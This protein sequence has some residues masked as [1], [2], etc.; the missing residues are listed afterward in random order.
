MRSESARQAKRKIKTL[1]IK[2]DEKIL[3]CLDRDVARS[4]EQ[5]EEHKESYSTIVRRL[6]RRH[7]K[8]KIVSDMACE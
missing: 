6:L 5:R 4:A 2:V 1:G 8:I 3:R 7:Y